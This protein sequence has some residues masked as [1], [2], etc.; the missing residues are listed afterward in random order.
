MNWVINWV[1]WLNMLEEKKFHGSLSLYF[2]WKRH[3]H[4]S[5]D[6]KTLAIRRFGT[7]FDAAVAAWSA[8]IHR[9]CCASC[10]HWFHWNR[11]QF[12]R[13]MRWP[14][15][16]RFDWMNAID[17]FGSPNCSV[18]CFC[19]VLAFVGA[20]EIHK[21]T[22]FHPRTSNWHRWW[23]HMCPSTYHRS[24]EMIFVYCCNW[25]DRPL[26]CPSISSGKSMIDRA[27]CE[28]MTISTCDWT[29]ALT[30]NSFGSIAA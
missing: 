1:W 25:C 28:T 29:F 9:N 27:Y 21:K 17:F 11:C 12:C 16:L 5:I 13:A 22:A 23:C 8:S 2:S 18:A 26:K 30:A 24:N 19:W 10:I 14:A 4:F 20:A 15:A 3:N 6:W 7:C